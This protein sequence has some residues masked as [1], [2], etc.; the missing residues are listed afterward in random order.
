MLF[1]FQGG[2]TSRRLANSYFYYSI[3]NNAYKGWGYSIVL[4]KCFKNLSQQW[5]Y[6]KRLHSPQCRYHCKHRSSDPR[7]ECVLS[8]LRST[9]DS[10][11]QQIQHQKVV[12][13]LPLPYLSVSQ[14]RLQDII[15]QT[16]ETLIPAILTF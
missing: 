4:G 7:A 6:L 16:G 10:N 13:S 11:A 2:N 8:V 14:Q 1:L 9:S 12:S 15:K 5:K 3:G